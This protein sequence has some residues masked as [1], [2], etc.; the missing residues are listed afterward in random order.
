M[1]NRRNGET[2]ALQMKKLFLKEYDYGD[3]AGNQ[4][5]TYYVLFTH[6]MQ[7]FGL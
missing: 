3:D 2:I 4:K 1:E 6:Q 5:P 7:L